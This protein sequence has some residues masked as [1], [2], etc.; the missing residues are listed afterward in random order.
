M[1][2]HYAHYRFG[3]LILASM[4]PEARRCIQRFR[5]M[6]DVG[7]HGPDLLFY[8]NIFLKDASGDLA[9]Q[10]HR[11]SGE[12]FFSRVCS[13]LRQEPSEAAMAYLYG[14]LAHYCLDSL[15]H[16][17]IGAAVQDGQ[18]GH[19]EL[20]TEF[21][22]FLLALDGKHPPHTFD[23]SAHMRLTRG[24]CVTV[25]A[26]YPP[27]TPG[28]VYHS[29]RTMAFSV[30]ILASPKG[31]ARTAVNTAVKLTGGALAPHIMTRTPNSRCSHLNDDLLA[32]FDQALEA[33]PRMLESLSAHISH[34]AP[35]GEEF[36]KCFG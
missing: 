5:Q 25:S 28:V 21:D 16:P 14:V 12:D 24:E 19:V 11:Q 33:Y 26:F 13:Q 30:K 22:R 4:R 17:Y 9:R 18:V 20:E 35:L 32:L 31:V 6:Y 34:N 10:F 15:C 29:I 2:S 36:E 23:C 1:P 3:S 27:A 8:H 7:L